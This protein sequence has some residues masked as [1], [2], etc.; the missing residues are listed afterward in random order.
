MI[1]SDQ[2]DW[3]KA[4]ETAEGEEQAGIP[5]SPRLP[6]TAKEKRSLLSPMQTT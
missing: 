4:S 6:P 2:V 5:A 1:S 3:G